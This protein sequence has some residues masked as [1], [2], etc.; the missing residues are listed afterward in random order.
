MTIGVSQTQM[1]IASLEVSYEVTNAKPDFNYND[2]MSFG[3]CC[4]RFRIIMTNR[5]TTTLK[6]ICNASCSR[7]LGHQ[8]GVKFL[9]LSELKN[10]LSAQIFS[11]CCLSL[12]S[13]EK[14]ILSNWLTFTNIWLTEGIQPDQNQMDNAI[15]MIEKGERWN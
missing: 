13:L 12:S 6:L 14:V 10:L 3:R 2:E 5:R 15:S 4:L 7:Y 8:Q 9:W 11:I 1:T